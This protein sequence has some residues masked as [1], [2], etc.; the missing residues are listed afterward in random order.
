MVTMRMTREVHCGLPEALCALH[1]FAA[2]YGESLLAASGRPGIEFICEPLDDEL[3]RATQS[4]EVF[5][6][7]WSCSPR[8]QVPTLHGFVSAC[9]NGL[10]TTII[11]DAIYE[12]EIGIVGALFDRCVGR[13]F[14]KGATT[15]FFQ[16]LLCFIE[17]E[18]GLDSLL[19]RLLHGGRST[20]R[21]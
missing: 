14:A 4:R 18:A 2:L 17:Q 15:S 5:F 13:R 7:H 8:F 3:S 1:I 12:P 6:V 11:F 20:G 10:T 9:P 19:E 21:A 16:R